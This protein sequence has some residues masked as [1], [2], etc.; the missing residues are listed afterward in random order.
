MTDKG[1][2]SKEKPM[3]DALEIAKEVLDHA[4][5]WK[6]MWLADGRFADYNFQETVTLAAEVVRLSEALEQIA[7]LGNKMSAS[8]N[9]EDQYAVPIARAA[10]THRDTEG[11]KG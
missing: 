10:L 6:G 5:K 8:I 9:G 3:S 2:P 11:G 7:N 4:D 1:T